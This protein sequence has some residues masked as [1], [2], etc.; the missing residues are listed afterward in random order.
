MRIIN[1]G[2]EVVAPYGIDDWDRPLRKT[3]LEVNG[4]ARICEVGNCKV[5]VVDLRNY[6]VV[7]VV[8]VIEPINPYRTDLHPGQYFVDD[9][10]DCV[11]V[12]AV[13]SN[14]YEAAQFVKYVG[15]GG[16]ASNIA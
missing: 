2:L 12:R 11:R 13:E 5:R 1:T 7:Y 3:S 4:R 9:I 15:G 14:C 10:V 16:V 8:I 6:P